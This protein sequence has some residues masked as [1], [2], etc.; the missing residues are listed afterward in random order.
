MAKRELGQGSSGVVFEVED[1]ENGL[2]LALKA[3]RRVTPASVL[4]LK[5]EFRAL[6][7]VTHPNLVLLHELFCEQNEWFF[8]MELVDG[9]PVVDRRGPKPLCDDLDGVEALVERFSQLAHGISALHARGILHR[10]LKPGNVLLAPDGRVVILDFGLVRRL[11]D[12]PSL[13]QDSISFSGTLAY[14]A[15][16]QVLS[17]Q[18]TTACDWYSFGSMLYEAIC[19]RLP[20]SGHPRTV[21]TEKLSGPRPLPDSLS[22]ERQ[23]ALGQLCL[24]LLAPA[25]ERRPSGEQ[26]LERLGARISLVPRSGPLSRDSNAP[27]IGRDAEFEQL[28]QA[29]R[30]RPEAPTRLVLVSGASGTGKTTLV[31]RVLGELAERPSTLLLAARCHPYETVPYNAL[32]GIVDELARALSVRGSELGELV[33]PRDVPALFQLFPA[34]KTAPGLVARGP[35]EAIDDPA[36]LRRRGCSA[37]R[38]LLTRLAQHFELVLFIDDLQWGDADSGWLMRELLLPPTP[39]ELLLAGTFRDDEQ[40][41]PLVRALLSEARLA[42]FRHLLS[43]SALSEESAARV[44]ERLGEFTPETTSIILKQANGNP[45]LL[46]ELSRGVAEIGGSTSASVNLSEVLAQRLTRLPAAAN[47]LMQLVVLPGRAIPVDVALEALEFGS[48]EL[49]HLA[50]L[51]SA[52]LVR[53]RSVGG[54]RRVEPYHDKI[55]ETL[56]SQLLPEQ[57]SKLFARLVAALS[58]KPHNDIELLADALAGAGDTERAATA[59]EK[60]AVV[61]ESALAFAR[62]AE[63]YRAALRLGSH[64]QEERRVLERKLGEALN[65]AG[66]GPQAAEALLRAASGAAPFEA[67]DLK[68]K[69]AAALLM[70][71]RLPEGRRVLAD[72]LRAVGIKEPSSTAAVL[73]ALLTERLRL[74]SKRLEVG[75]RALSSEEL[76]E[77]EAVDVAASSYADYDTLRGWGYAQRG[78]RLALR[79]ADPGKLLRALS[80]ELLYSSAEGD[81]G[82]AWVSRLIALGRRLSNELSEP[83]TLAHFDTACGVHAL[84]NT[85]WDEA[86]HALARAEERFRQSPGGASWELGFVRRSYVAVVQMQ[87]HMVEIESKIRDYTEDARDRDDFGAL[88]ANLVGLGFT[89]LAKDQPQE[90]PAVLEEIRRVQALAGGYVELHALWAEAEWLIYSGAEP[91]MLHDCLERMARFD[92][93]PASHVRFFRLWNAGYEWRLVC[94]ELARAEGSERKRL[95]KTCEQL[96]RRLKREAWGPAETQAWQVEATLSLLNG[97]QQRAADLLERS[98]QVNARDG[99]RIHASAARL[100]RARILAETQAA[101]RFLDEIRALRVVNPERMA[102]SLVPLPLR[103]LEAHRSRAQG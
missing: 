97:H 72:V 103:A 1:A 16:E 71:G 83:S 84:L 14:V 91:P 27:L 78:L 41:T 35:L 90:V 44:V 53:I 11:D 19:G 29:M 31:R 10:D 79:G 62:A 102:Y 18:L 47:E 23:R 60:A 52:G 28:T 74:R 67:I 8:T 49:G 4:Q 59:A 96:L 5:R 24:E 26:V 63:W 15:P 73:G 43:L 51:R 30:R 89:L 88:A 40:H 21:L 85:R 69:A 93:G 25:P 95:T 48:A 7:D 61:A 2:T 22:G 66:H 87:G 92:R 6:A 20:F 75:A 38:E 64:S 58:R 80:R 12:E 57:K 37:L 45:F 77:L 86:A 76:L 34:L 54:T 98:A 99:A 100:A 70:S 101:N 33:A 82:S 68:R 13:R 36:E 65:N 32:D 46:C 81:T 42:T 9:L 39:P 3:L 94:C 55:R 50:S 17:H 56:A